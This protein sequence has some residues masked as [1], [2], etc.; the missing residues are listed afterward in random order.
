MSLAPCRLVAGGYTLGMSTNTPDNPG[1]GEGGQPQPTPPAFDPSAQHQRTPRVRPVRGFPVQH[2]EQ[3]ILGLA[4]AQ[5]IS[6]K[7]VFT[8]PAAQ[9]LLPHMTGEKDL[10]AIV[11]EVG[12]GLTRSMLEQFVAQLDDAGL[13]EGP[14]FDEMLVQMRSDYDSLDNLPPAMTAL[15]AD[16][17]VKEEL[18]EETTPEKMAEMGPEKLRVQMDTWIDKALE[19]AKD[20]SFETLPKAVVTPHIDYMR[21]WINYAQVYGRMRVVDRPDRIIILGTNHFGRSTGVCGCDKGFETPLGLCELDA[22]F[23]GALAARLGEADTQKLYAERYDHEREHSIETQ[24]PWIQH[25]FG[26]A[27]GSF[28]TIYGALVHDPCVSSGESYDGQGLALAPFVEA[29][30]GAM[31]DVG[32]RTLIVCS[33]DLSH[34][35]AQFGDRIQMN[36]DDEQAEQARQKVI[37]HDREM[38][39]LFAEGKPEEIVS[40]L[41]WQQNP[42]RWCSVGAMTATFQAVAPA[43]VRLIHYHGAIDPGGTALVTCVSAAIT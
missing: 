4:D 1:M 18:G 42:T 30:R 12:R 38:L 5:Q 27:D 14:K 8:A 40:R 26:A 24:I 23:A 15:F 13:L 17:L 32:G 36:A 2:G 6:Q 20:P 39:S 43:T 19:E 3:V 35:G 28:P 11:S 31:E 29:L 10:D 22:P 21:G 34:V 25:V 16:L 41:A 33:A 37:G 9:A 7:V